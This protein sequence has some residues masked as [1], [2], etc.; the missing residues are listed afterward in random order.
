MVPNVVE[1]LNVAL[2]SYSGALVTELVILK[3]G[4]VTRTTSELAPLLLT[5]TAHQWENVSALDR[6]K[7][8]KSLYASGTGLAC[9]ACQPLAHDHKGTAVTERKKSSGSN[10]L[11]KPPRHFNI[12]TV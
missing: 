7:V 1:Y 10:A 2:F 3:H 6:C 5:T 12:S 8:H 11:S 4:Q 9:M